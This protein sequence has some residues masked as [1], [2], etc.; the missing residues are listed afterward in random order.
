MDS[1]RVY[2]VGRDQS[3]DIVIEHGS[4]SRHHCELR[5]ADD[6][7]VLLVDLDSMN[8]TAVRQNGAWEH[9]DKA[10][11]ERD[12]RI[13]LGE[14][15]TT[16]AALL[17]RAPKA[18]SAERPAAAPAP[19][20]SPRKIPKPTTPAFKP[21]RSEN[22]NIMSR[23]IKSDWARLHRRSR[24]PKQIERDEPS[25]CLP[26]FVS[27]ADAAAAEAEGDLARLMR[28]PPSLLAK[29]AALPVRPDPS[30]GSSNA[31]IVPPPPEPSLA[32]GA[33]VVPPA[34]AV[35]PPAPSDGIAVPPRESPS[36]LIASR[37][38]DPMFGA[39]ASSPPPSARRARRRV[40]PA[41]LPRPS[42]PEFAKWA[43]V[44][45]ALLLMSGGA[46]ATY[47]QYAPEPEARVARSWPAPG[48]EEKSPRIPA[49]STPAAKPVSRP[50]MPEKPGDE[51]KPEIARPAAPKT[52]ETPRAAAR[53]WQRSIEGT[54]DSV[55]AAAAPSG[56]GLCLAGTTS[57]SGGHEAW[58]LRTD[59]EGQ[60]RW[61]RR[62]GGPKR[63]GALAVTGST[64]GGCVAAGYDSDETKL[65][66]FKLDAK[67][68]LAWSRSIPA[69][70][71]GRAVAILRTRDGGYAVAAHA[72]PAADKP[73]RAFVLRLSP[74]GEIQW[75][76][77]AGKGES[78]AADLRETRD[79]GFVLAG[80][81]RGRDER[82]AL[83][84]ARL[85]RKG[86]TLW[87]KPFEGPGAP[88]SARIDVARGTEF[89][90][91]AA[92]I[93]PKPAA[94]DAEP[95]AALRLIRIGEGGKLLWDQRH[96]GAARHVAGLVVMKG[97]LLV[98]GDAGDGQAELW[99]GQFDAGG[100][101]MRESR[102]P[103]ARGDRAAALAE[104]AN[105]RIVLVGTAA[106]ETAAKRGAGITFLDR[107]RQLAGR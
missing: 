46:Y 96:G 37:R 44:G 88:E 14:I 25:I 6:G 36:L 32:L 99:L 42:S 61:Q 65:W 75:S 7:S 28:S 3:N 21:D 8:G 20:R 79:G 11:V 78:R 53:P 35:V 19:A 22:S 10:S 98:A 50:S 55:I 94:G 89:I 48:E 107:D 68:V 73:D 83:W 101:M 95:G 9:V 84:A 45:S 39:A 67:G 62:P 43:V 74:K 63:D 52:P 85:D 92:M 16:V 58:I 82:L 23:L 12:E 31:R 106:L 72:R 4:V 29:P 59:G 87:D 5:L 2:R 57:L 27:A 93:G 76:K 103:A 80:F 1:G 47:L 60:V 49:P 91:A 100:R 86:H 30:S 54:P 81:V 105:G 64:D 38:T 70:H 69:G 15:V 77:Y 13:L 26:A 102:L 17:M 104:L 40:L 24:N 18:P 34:V 41:W 71:S 56:D 33:A 90:I 51:R 66:I 97:G